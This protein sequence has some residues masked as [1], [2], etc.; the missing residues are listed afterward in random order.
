MSLVVCDPFPWQRRHPIGPIL[1]NSS[2][3]H[4]RV[5]GSGR[6]RQAAARNVIAKEDD[7][8]L[9]VTLFDGALRVS[10]GLQITPSMQWY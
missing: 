1:G 4:Q 9:V 7:P 5:A 2:H 10:E 8:L 6:R 3:Q